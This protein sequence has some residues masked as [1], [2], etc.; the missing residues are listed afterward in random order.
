MAR[1]DL[2]GHSMTNQRANYQLTAITLGMILLGGTILGSAPFAFA[3]DDDD[4]KEKVK[5][6]FKKLLEEI[7]AKIEKKK[8]PP[9]GDPGDPPDKCKGTKYGEICDDSAPS[10]GIKKPKHRDR[11]PAGVPFAV[12]IK[13]KDGQTAVDMVEVFINNVFIGEAVFVSGEIYEIV[14]VVLNDP[15]RYKMKA[16]ATDLVGN[17][18]SDKIQF[19]IVD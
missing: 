8:G 17:I 1:S 13:A 5:G 10:V 3:D 19:F 14:G 4:K 11:L 9:G 12:E 15:G 16:T 7:I 6:K 18:G 2:F